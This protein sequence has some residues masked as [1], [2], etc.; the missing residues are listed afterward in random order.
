MHPSSVIDPSAVISPDA[1]IGP[2]CYV[3]P[4]VTIGAG[5]V[6]LHRVSVI[7]NTIMGADNTA[8]PGAVLGAD[9]QDKKYVGEET[10]L[11]IGDGNTFRENVTIHRGTDL[12]GSETRVGNGCLIMAGAHIA[13]DCILGDRVTM[14]NHVLLGGHIV[15]EDA[16]GFGGLSAVHHYV[17]IGR[18]SFVGGMTRVISDVPPYMI[19][20]GHPSRVRA[21]N[22]V[23]LKRHGFDEQIIS[24]LKDAY[25]LL[26]HDGATVNEEAL[27]RLRN[28]GPHTADAKAFIDFVSES[29]KGKQ[30]RRRQP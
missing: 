24:W 30:G 10:W 18:Y 28:E 20:E 25:R 16:V 19:T 14:A 12:G 11:R 8:Y 7:A 13:H 5:S 6:L 2:F 1:S 26:Y 27:E 29:R 3:G 9:P 4:G 22:R 21:V 17:S 15:V 23:G